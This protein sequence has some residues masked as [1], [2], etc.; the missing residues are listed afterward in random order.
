MPPLL[1]QVAQGVDRAVGELHGRDRDPDLPA[2]EVERQ[3]LGVLGGVD[4]GARHGHERLDRRPA[5]EDVLGPKAEHLAGVETGDRG[6]RGVPEPHD[7]R[8]IDEED[9]V[10]DVCEH[11]RRPLALLAHLRLEP[12]ALE[13]VA[14]LAGDQLRDRQRDSVEA[15][16]S[17]DGIERQRPDSG[18]LMPDRDDEGAP[19]ADRAGELHLQPTFAGHVPDDQRP[20][21]C[22]ER[23][24]EVV[25]NLEGE[26]APQLVRDPARRLGREDPALGVVEEQDGGVGA[27]GRGGSFQ[28][29]AADLPD[30]PLLGGQARDRAQHLELTDPPRALGAAAQA[31]P[32]ALR[33]QGDPHRGGEGRR[34]DRDGDERRRVDRTAVARRHAD[35][36]ELLD[37]RADEEQAGRKREGRT[38]ETALPP[39]GPEQE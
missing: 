25:G 2:A 38:F 14:C 16:R 39:P 28:D 32:A 20:A 24:I 27:D 31:L 18:P 37:A 26:R 33:R 13:D 1:R 22:E 10:A 36:D 19:R 7:A 34:D 17:G 35:E 23:L 9:A 29:R 3:R 21:A 11:P 6:D 30:R 8:A 15:P 5:G 4:R 12:D